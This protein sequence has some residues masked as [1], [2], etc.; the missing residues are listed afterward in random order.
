[1]DMDFDYPENPPK[2]SHVSEE[3]VW[4]LI[5]DKFRN[6]ALVQAAR[7]LDLLRKIL[8]EGTPIA[9]KRLFE[10]AQSYHP[11]RIVCN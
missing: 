2:P 7:D 6:N 4:D 9:T 8:T 3:E 11:D 10:A 1:M 5:V